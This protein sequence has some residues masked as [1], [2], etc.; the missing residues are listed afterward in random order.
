M[1]LLGRERSQ[2][3]FEF[4]GEEPGWG[5]KWGELPEI[6]VFEDRCNDVGL[7]DHTAL[8]GTAMISRV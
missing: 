5:S 8:L 1:S 2:D 7:F 4:L 6:E 3:A